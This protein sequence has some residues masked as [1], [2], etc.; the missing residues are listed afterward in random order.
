MAYF[1]LTDEMEYYFSSKKRN[2]D[3][4]FDIIN[5]VKEKW[6]Q[7][8]KRDYWIAGYGSILNERSRLKT[9]PNTID[10]VPAYVKGWERIFNLNCKTQTVLNVRPAKANNKKLPVVAVNIP[11]LDMFDFIL[12]ERNYDVIE[13]ELFDDDGILIDDKAIMVVA[14]EPA[15]IADHWPNLS[16]VQAN[17][18]GA[19]GL[20][21]DEFVEKYLDTTF[22]TVDDDGNE[23]PIREYLT[24]YA[25]EHCKIVDSS[26]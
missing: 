1:N 10:A 25:I 17:I 12:R 5:A 21:G 11:Y 4:V 26:Y 14:N 20:G 16:Y 8:E 24:P 2:D 15:Q 19:Y 13:T 22:F 6:T 18:H 7:I 3:E 9:L 23:L